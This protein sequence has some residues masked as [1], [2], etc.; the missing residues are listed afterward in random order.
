M[1]ETPKGLRLHIGIFGRRNSGKSTLMNAL[2]GQS[3][4]IVSDQ[5][6]TTTDPVEKTFELAP[7]GPVVFI[8]T[9]GLDDEGDLGALRIEKTRQVLE[10]VDVALVVVDAGGMTA[11]ERDLMAT[12]R[13]ANTPFAIVFNK[14]DLG[15]PPAEQLAQL[16][17]E[18]IE[19]VSISAATGRGIDRVKEA[20][21]RQAPESS[22]EDP[23]LVGDLIG[24]G[25]LVV[26][27]VPIDLGAPKGRLIL[28]QVQT[29]R[30]IL[31][32]DAVGLMVKERE[33]AA[34]LARMSDKPRLVVC[35]SQVVNKVSADTPPD[36]RMTTFSI[37]MAR[38]KGDMIGLAEGAG[39]I[40]R[41]KPGDKVLIA[42]ACSHHALADDI[43]RVKIP[44]WLR[45][46]AGGNL[47]IEVRSGKDFPE[48][49]SSYALIVQCGGCT[50][51]RKQILVRQYRAAQ[52]GVPM[53]NYGM[54]ISVSQG[55]IER[56]LECFPAALDAYRRGMAGSAR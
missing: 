50:V 2:I 26:L 56:A 16:A 25:D 49:L 23:R 45:Q 33:L 12:L 9:A 30:D 14:S 18:A 39:A 4:S 51:T 31:D 11:T 44:R 38:F 43:G 41:L 34:A 5:P 52:Q 29:M 17:A 32:S 21:F 37:L 1:L 22:I 3:V 8:D 46:Y 24:P 19:T 15:E 20:L 28:P 53:T 54:A 47:D 48:D 10:R 13:A 35:D 55:V 27:V 36:I 6:G 42:E 7:L 40:S